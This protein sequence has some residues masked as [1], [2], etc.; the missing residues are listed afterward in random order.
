MSAIQFRET[1]GRA[2]EPLNSPLM[3]RQFPQ[4]VESP[5]FPCRGLSV[6][7]VALYA[8]A[9]VS[10]L[11][12]N[13]LG[14]AGNAMFFAV[15]ALLLVG[16]PSLSLMG[17]SCAVLALTANVAFVPKS[18]V[19]TF[20]RVLSVAIFSARFA[21]AGDTAWMRSP[22]YI[23]L[24]FFCA[25]AATCS[26]VSGYFT[27]IALM[28]ILVF[29][30]GMTG[31]FAFIATIRQRKIDT[32]EWFVAQAG[33][34]CILN[35]LALFLGVAQNFKGENVSHGLYNLGLYHSQTAGP[36]AALLM[37]Y[38]VCL[39]LFAG[40]RNRWICWPLLGFL[41]YGL[42][43]TQSRTGAATLAVGLSIVAMFAFLFSSGR[44]RA[45]R[46]NYS[47]TLIGLCMAAA[48]LSGILFDLGSQGS[49]TTRVRS[50]LIKSRRDSENVSIDRIL[51][52]RAALI[53]QSL[54]NFKASPI[55]GIGFGVS[56]NPNF[57]Q[58]ATIL[59]APVEKGFLPTALLEEVGL[60]GTITFIGFILTMFTS[61][62]RSRN[63]P[64][65]AM[66]AAL[67]TLNLGE[68]GIF[69]LGGHS[70]F[71]WLFVVGGILLGDRCITEGRLR[72]NLNAQIVRNNM[73]SFTQVQP[74]R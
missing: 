40:H 60:L 62:A 12:A 11:L 17:F 4:S 8:C 20:S 36:I 16:S 23:A 66:F 70:A 63:I 53:E 9:T 31:F 34:V 29:W 1:K 65:I 72:D 28:K 32:T 25:V 30:T 19:F 37:I 21:F 47:R 24:T 50:F 74:A 22:P 3:A 6:S 64:G 14:F 2:Y 44:W 67:L 18:I 59:Y 13:V 48:L 57:Q 35:A 33:A 10:F 54:Q 42:F 58:N 15:V 68:A 45:T 69:A 27:H 7:R 26:I 71:M 38:L 41:A 46:L 56:T 39:V 43:L 49:L 51:S 55:V 5:L 52:S 61:L 73:R